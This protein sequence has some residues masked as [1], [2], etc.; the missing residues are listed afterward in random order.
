M[1]EGIYPANA[2]GG[3]EAADAFTRVCTVD[4]VSIKMLKMLR[5]VNPMDRQRFFV[6]ID[7]FVFY[8]GGLLQRLVKIF[9][10]DTSEA[11]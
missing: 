4:K 8:A 9:L 7:S 5:A 6:K 11:D 3:G 2:F 10:I 1:A